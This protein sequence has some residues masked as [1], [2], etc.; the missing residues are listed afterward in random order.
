MKF[1]YIDLFC[2]IGGFRIAADSY[3]GQCLF[4][5]DIAKNA[6]TT[7]EYNYGEKPSGDIT[8][9]ETQSLIPEHFDLLCGGFPCQAFSVAGKRKGFEDTR[10]TLFFYVADIIRTHRPKVV[11]LENVKGLLGHDNGRTFETI[12][13]ILNDLNYD[14]HWKPL[15]SHNFGVPQNRERVYIVCFNKDYYPQGVSFTYP[16]PIKEKDTFPIHRCLTKEAN[17]DDSLYFKTSFRHYDE[18]RRDIVC[19]DY[20]YQWRRKYVRRNRTG[21]CPTMTVVFTPQIVLTPKGLRDLSVREYL[22]FQGFPQDFHF[23]PQLARKQCCGLVGNSVSVPVVKLIIEQI[24]K[25]L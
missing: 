17:E 12:I 23:P 16:E 22:N 11:F 9:P 15:N 13:S 6:C 10:G 8:L 14:V 18:L 19:P 7:Y 3:G 25:Y 5:S 21:V 4:S 1:T 2:G 24:T 20:I